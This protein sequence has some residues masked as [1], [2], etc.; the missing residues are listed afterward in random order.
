MEDRIFNQNWKL[1]RNYISWYNCARHWSCKG[2]MTKN[3]HS[4]SADFVTT[5]VKL[6][7]KLIRTAFSFSPGE[8]NIY[9]NCLLSILERPIFCKSESITSWKKY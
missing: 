9:F 2:T 5:F 6:L 4:C 3:K 1:I 8:K 7:M